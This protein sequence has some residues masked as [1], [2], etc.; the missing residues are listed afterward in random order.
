MQSETG[1]YVLVGVVSMVVLLIIVFIVAVCVR[2]RRQ[3]A[4]IAVRS[5]PEEIGLTRRLVRTPR[6]DTWP[7]TLEAGSSP[8]AYASVNSRS[9]VGGGPKAKRVYTGDGCRFYNVPLTKSQVAV[10]PPAYAAHASASNPRLASTA[11]APF[12]RLPN[13]G[14]EPE[15]E[16]TVWRQ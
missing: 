15:Q 4:R 1:I 8:S 3:R 11:Y 10:P 5:G 12:Y 9:V 2:R 14:A 6:S 7:S 13:T 16:R